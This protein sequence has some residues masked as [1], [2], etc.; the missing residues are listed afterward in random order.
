MQAGK[1]DRK[2]SIQRRTD[3]R[4]AHGQPIPDWSQ[5]GLSRWARKMPVEGSERF[6]ADQ[7][8]SREQVTWEVR[9]STDLADLN[10]K[11]RIVYPITAPS[12]TPLDSEI[13]EIM[14]V[15]EVGRRVG[16]RIMTARRSEI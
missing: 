7:F 1:L 14:A 10:P 16:L 8:I 15:I 9:W 11:D 12:G 6:I 3:T 13:Y 5:I 4:D 2:I